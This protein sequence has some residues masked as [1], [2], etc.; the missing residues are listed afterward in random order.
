MLNIKYKQ[1]LYQTISAI[2]GIGSALIS[3]IWGFVA[4]NILMVYLPYN[5]D[6]LAAGYFFIYGFF[7]AYAIYNY[8]VNVKRITVK[9]AKN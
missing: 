1:I 5:N 8:I 3:T 4:L 7:P 9:Y 6:I 2:K